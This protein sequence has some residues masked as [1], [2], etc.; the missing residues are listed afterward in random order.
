MSLTRRAIIPGSFHV[1]TDHF[2]PPPTWYLGN[3]NVLSKFASNY[4][5]QADDT[6]VISSEDITGQLSLGDC[7]GVYGCRR[8]ASFKWR[9]GCL[10]TRWLS[11]GDQETCPT[12]FER[13]WCKAPWKSGVDCK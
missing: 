9:A 1:N 2:E 3:R 10:E 7:T 8:R 12:H 5:F 11:G 4:G 6:V 13:F